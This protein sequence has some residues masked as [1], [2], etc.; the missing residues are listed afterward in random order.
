[1]LHSRLLFLRKPVQ[2]LALFLRLQCTIQGSVRQS[3]NDLLQLYIAAAEIKPRFDSELE[4]IAKAS[5]G[6]FKR[7]SLKHL[8]R[9]LEKMAMKQSGDRN[10]GRADSVLDI[11]RCMLEYKTMAAMAAGVRALE[12]CKN[13]KVIRVKDRFSAPTPGG[14][15]D[16]MVSVEI[17]GDSS[18]HVCEV[19][20]VHKSLLAVRKDMGG[21]DE[22][23]VYRSV[24]ELL[25]VHG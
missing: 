22:Y 5:K 19:Q 9:T 13:V 14:W 21:H 24:A 11:V 18:K 2:Q 15:T 3:V 23:A 8:Y 20:F 6:V 1:M 25:E 10:L 7:S 17:K 4:K 12:K 16:V